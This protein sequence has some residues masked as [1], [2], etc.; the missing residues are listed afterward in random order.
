MKNKKIKPFRPEIDS[1]FCLPDD[2]PDKLD[3]DSKKIAK[4]LIRL[5]KEPA[6]TTYKDTGK[7]IKVGPRSPDLFMCLGTVSWVTYENTGVFL[8]VLVT[9]KIEKIPGNG[10]F[11]LVS[12]FHKVAYSKLGHDECFEKERKLIY[13]A[14]KAGELNFILTK[15][16][17][18]ALPYDMGNIGD[19]LKHGVMAEFIRWWSGINRHEE[20]FVFLDPFC[21]LRWKRSA[22]EKALKRL[23][24]LRDRHGS[25]FEIINAQP[26]IDECKY[27]G[28][29]YVVINQT[30][31]VSQKRDL[32]LLPVIFA[33]DKSHD[34]ETALEEIDEHIE[35][36]EC[37]GFCKDNGYSIL[38]SV[39]DE[40]IDAD[41]VL[42][43]P[44]YGINDIKKITQKIIE[45][46]EKTTVVLF[47]LINTDRDTAKWED[48]CN[49]LN[50]NSIILTCP[51][52]K[53]TKI[54][55]ECYYKVGVILTSHLLADAEANKLRKKLKDYADKLTKIVGE[56]SLSKDTITCE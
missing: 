56:E 25:D 38:C 26:G 18:S 37:K 15:K 8:S 13:D 4:Y 30:L 12:A 2:Y 47:V 52:L 42:I 50:K 7:K 14:A 51:P 29:I 46:S 27:Y 49:K 24:K 55:G 10:F 39:A 41:M 32:P 23:R 5:A 48:I 35:K 40:H 53:E 28:S 16:D 20:K 31:H 1:K 11:K 45:A 43:D 22:N 44:F 19:L 17:T 6:V 21:G 34:S 33:S 36:L 9:R 3:K 54:R